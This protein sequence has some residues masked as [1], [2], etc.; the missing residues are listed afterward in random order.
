[1]VTINIAVDDNELWSEVF[2][3]GFEG[4]SH[5]IER[6]DFVEGD[7]TTAGKVVIHADDY[8]GNTQVVPITVDDLGK[9]LQELIK[10][11]SKHCGGYLIN[12]TF[13]DWDACVGDMILQYAVWGNLVY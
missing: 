12:A 6:I 13:D 11:N 2:G 3:S 9:A 4:E 7:W 10:R 1:M 5:W 8:E